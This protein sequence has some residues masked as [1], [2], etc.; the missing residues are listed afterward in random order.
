M[1]K[2]IA[3][4]TKESGKLEQRQQEIKQ[5]K[6]HDNEQKTEFLTDIG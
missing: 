5:I 3:I 1:I 2:W 6:V 4:I